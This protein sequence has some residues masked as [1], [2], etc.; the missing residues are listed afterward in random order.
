MDN[1]NESQRSYCMSR[2]RAKGTK[3]ELMVRRVLHKLG[4]RFR[5]HRSDLRGAP[6]I[7]LPRLRTAI[8]VH[9]CFWHQHPD[10]RW[11]TKPASNTEYW[12]SKL[13]G[14]V[15]RSRDAVED[16]MRAGWKVVIVW[17]CQTRDY[18]ELRARM[19]ELLKE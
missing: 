5:L 10:C 3:P 16:L 11:A 9:G 19:S 17:E 7:V 18:G 2:I 1:L 6:D 12:R 15:Q 14:N 13:Q 4:Y 8:F